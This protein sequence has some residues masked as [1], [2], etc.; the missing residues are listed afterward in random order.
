[1]LVKG[2]TEGL[3]MVPLSQAIEVDR[4]RE[5][6]QHEL[7][8]DIASPQILVQ[9]GWPPATAEPIPRTPRRPVNDVI[10]DAGSLPTW[11]GPYHD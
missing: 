4:T 2:A 10:G 3:A 8:A 7:L 5:L 9:V 6:L 1:M 11:M